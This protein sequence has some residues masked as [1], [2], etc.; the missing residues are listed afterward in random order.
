MGSPI[1]SLI[2]ATYGRVDEIGR[3]LDSL[4]AQTCQDF[5]LI[6]VD[7]NPDDRVRPFVQR[8]LQAGWQVQHLR[9]SR[10]NL[11][12]A[13][14]AGIAVAKGE[15]IALPD[16]DCWYESDTLVRVL[17]RVRAEP[18]LDGV[19]ARWVEQTHKVDPM[20]DSPLRLEA[21]RQFKGSDAS[22]IA[23][24]LRTTLARQ[25]GGF[26]ERLGVG[27]WFGA[28]EETDFLLSLLGQGARIDRLADARVHHAFGARKASLLRGEWRFSLSR[29]R[30]WGALCRKHRLSH[31]VVL[32]GLV[33]PMSWLVL[34]PNGLVGLV[35]SVA[36]TVGRLQGLVCWREGA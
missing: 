2:L 33:G 16:D 18:V 8:A 13:R 20:L 7:Q 24:F 9:L 5:E 30:S 6:V 34:R 31:K 32:R 10:P 19:V 21:W 12:A 4:E 1:F 23:L 17:A 29:S 26:D 11:S 27:Q 14:N 15:W 28:G 25:V 3:L 22:S 35:Q 36:A